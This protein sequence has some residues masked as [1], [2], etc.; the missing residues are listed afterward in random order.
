MKKKLFLNLIVLLVLSMALGACAKTVVDS[1][2]S[3]T[4]EPTEEA[5][6][7]EAVQQENEPEE[8]VAKEIVMGKTY[9]PTTLDAHNATDSDT[10]DILFLEFEGLVR[11]KDGVIVPGIAESWDVSE[12]GMEYTFHLRESM[13]SDG[14]PLTAYDFE[15]SYLRVIDP[16]TAYEQANGFYDAIKNARAYHSGELTDVSEVGVKAIDDYTLKITRENPSVEALFVMARYPWF[17]INKTSAEANGLAYGSEAAKIVSNGPFT[18]TEWNHQD[19]LVLEKNEL[20]WDADNINLT[21]ITVLVGASGQTGVDMML[22]GTLDY[23]ATTNADEKD[24]LEEAGFTVES[25]TSQYQFLIM[26]TSYNTGKTEEGAKFMANA[27]FRLALSYAINRKAITDSLFPGAEPAYRITSPNT[28]GVNGLF[29]EE[30]PYQAWPVEGDPEKARYHLD[31]A[32]S[33]I[34]LTLDQAP[35]LFMLC[36]ESEQSMTI[37]QAVQDMVLNTLGVKLTLDPQPIQSMF[38]KAFGGDFDM[39][40]AGQPLGSTDWISPDSFAQSYDSRQADY[41]GGYINEEFL[42]RYIIATT[43]LNMEERKDNMFA[44]EKILCEQDPPFII[45]GWTQKFIITNPNLSGVLLSTI[46]DPT[47]M[48]LAVD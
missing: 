7:T 23:F 37:L 31:L 3:V 5:A 38:A 11:N 13:W 48:D 4:E 14:T 21:K 10:T 27:N 34:G 29:N 30:Y 35:E 32:L 9:D 47:Y 41:S 45:I 25:Y 24:T 12:D 19:K 1:T 28:M 42:A 33:E 20:Y 26:N 8:E 15:Y 17:P 46:A 44:I 39:W 22:A 16:G 2:E 36:Y 43:T 18:I 6:I 40:W